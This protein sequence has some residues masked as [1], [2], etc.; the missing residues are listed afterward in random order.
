MDTVLSGISE[1]DKV[2]GE[3][4]SEIARLKAQ[5][6][7][8][9]D[10]KKLAVGTA[11]ADKDKLIAELQASLGQKDQALQIA[12]LKERPVRRSILPKA[13]APFMWIRR[14]QPINALALPTVCYFGNLIPSC[15]RP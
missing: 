11:V 14:L 10:R 13:L 7:S 2:I 4:E 9:D 1:K 12:V 6:A 3:K 5:I 15:M 8:E